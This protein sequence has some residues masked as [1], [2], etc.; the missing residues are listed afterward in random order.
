MKVY[1]CILTISNMHIEEDTQE[2]QE[3]NHCINSYSA[4]RNN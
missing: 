3:Q 2:R 4:S 1:I